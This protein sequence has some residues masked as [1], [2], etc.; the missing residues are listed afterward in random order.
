[1][2]NSFFQFI[3]FRFYREDIENGEVDQYDFGHALVEKIVEIT[4][5]RV[6]ES[7]GKYCVIAEKSEELVP[8]RFE[9]IEEDLNKMKLMLERIH[10]A[11]AEN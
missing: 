2:P 6:S 9:K 3:P 5:E 7:R 10:E 4:K 11:V 8:Q 1:M